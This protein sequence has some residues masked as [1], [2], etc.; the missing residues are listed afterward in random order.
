M[1]EYITQEGIILLQKKM[2]N[3]L[4]VERPMVVK[5]IATAR[6]LGDLKENAEYHAARE[7]QRHI[8]DELT[9]IR[10]RLSKLQ[11]IDT[12]KIAKD[13]IRFGAYVTLKDLDSDE[14]IQY[15]LVGV[16]ETDFKVDEW[17]L[18]SVASPIG[19]SMI[20]K[21]IKQKFTVKAPIGD[22]QFEVM[23]IA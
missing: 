5:Q 15:R 2:N 6:E 7:R 3:L 14:L 21:K 17:T 8:D 22:R 18:I 12:S 1:P 9:R 13:A 19:K 11:A 10:G 16:D 23:S 4:T 20:G